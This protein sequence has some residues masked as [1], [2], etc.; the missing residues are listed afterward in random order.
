MS[1]VHLPLFLL[2]L[3]LP[4]SLATDFVVSGVIKCTSAKGM[5]DSECDQEVHIPALYAN[6]TVEL[7]E[8]DS[9]FRKR[10]RVGGGGEQMNFQR[11]N[12]FSD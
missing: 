12:E 4:S 10:R 3:Q 7:L 6:A 11:T 5:V 2:L 8:V 1:P 9:K